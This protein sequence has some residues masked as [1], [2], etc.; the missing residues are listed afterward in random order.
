MDESNIGQGR[1]YCHM[2]LIRAVVRA[3]FRHPDMRVEF[4]KAL[5][6]EERDAVV[7]FQPSF[8]ASAFREAAEDIE[9]MSR[10]P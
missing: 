10:K 9:S 1:S 3:A 5:R 6:A 8:V 4:A 2:H 7:E